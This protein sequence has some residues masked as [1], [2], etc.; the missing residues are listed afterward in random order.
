MRLSDVIFVNTA[1]PGHV[2]EKQQRYSTI[3]PSCALPV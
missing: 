1:N 2:D 3:L